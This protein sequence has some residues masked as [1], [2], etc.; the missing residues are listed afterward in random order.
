MPRATLDEAVVVVEDV[1]RAVVE[2]ALA[3]PK[4]REGLEGVQRSWRVRR[5]QVPAEPARVR[6]VVEEREVLSEKS[7][8]S[9]TSSS[10]FRRVSYQFWPIFDASHLSFDAFHLP[11][12]VRQ[13]SVCA[14][15]GPSILRTRQPRWQKAAMLL[16][17]LAFRLS[18]KPRNTFYASRSGTWPK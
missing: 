13:A 11:Q 5:L 17:C 6:A 14:P 10:A 15:A 12:L 2:H 4:G 18:F 3:A 7:K 8:L 16:R 9:A 1:A